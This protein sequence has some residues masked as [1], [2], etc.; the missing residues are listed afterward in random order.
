MYYLYVLELQN[1]QFYI[2]YTGNLKRR[3][4]EHQRKKEGC[5]LIYYEAYQ[6]EELAKE[7]EDKLKQYGSAWHGLKKRIS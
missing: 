2:G 4:L 7:R 1:K 5:V 3:V 6:E